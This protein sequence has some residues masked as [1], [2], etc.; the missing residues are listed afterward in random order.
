MGRREFGRYKIVEE[1]GRGAMGVVYRASDP[2]IGRT[3]AVKVVNAS[4]LEE[5][6]V[7]A[8]EYYRRFQREAE[9]AG[10][11]NHPN[12]VKIFDRGHDYLVMEFVEGQSLAA[13]IRGHV[14]LPLSRML[15][16]VGQIA[17]ALDY[18]H[19][20]G[21]VHRDVKP[22]N[23]MIQPDGVVKVMDFGLARIESS[24]LTAAGEILGSASYMA[25]E[26][27]M[28]TA[29]GAQS[30]IF[31]LGVVAYELMTGGRPFG[32]GSVSAIIQRIV[33][34]RPGSAHALN[35]SVPPDYDNI[36]LRVLAK[37]PS[38]R[39]K[40]AG[41][42]VD[43]LVL[44][45]WADRDPEA[46]GGA[47]SLPIAA[48]TAR[49]AIFPGAAEKTTTHADPADMTLLTVSA[50]EL[51]PAKEEPPGQKTT[52]ALRGEE[53]ELGGATVVTL[54]PGEGVGARGGAKTDLG[55]TLIAAAPVPPPPVLARPRATGPPPIPAPP[56]RPAPPPTGED[57][58]LAALVKD[59]PP[60]PPPTP[61]PL[62]TVTDGTP[63][64]APARPPHAPADASPGTDRVKALPVSP[65][66]DPHGHPPLVER[67]GPSL[68][69]VLGLVGL[70]FVILVAFGVG[71]VFYILRHRSAP[72]Q[73]LPPVTEAAVVPSPE[74]APPSPT[75]VAETPIPSPETQEVASS[76]EVSIPPSPAFAPALG[77]L[78]IASVPSGARVSLG[79]A[80]RGVTP[81][82]GSV[83]AGRLSV[84]VEKEGFKPWKRDVTIG[85]G[86][87]QTLRAELEPV[88]AVVPSPSVSA[89]PA[90]KTGDLVPLTPD[91]VPPRK[92]S[93]DAPAAPSAPKQKGTLS[94][95]V[96]FVVNDDGTVGGVRVVQSG[97]DALDRAALGAVSGWRYVPATL[98]GVRVKVQQRAK[99]T[100]EYR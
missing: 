69:L 52:P 71:G 5:V 2:V 95:V 31:G 64:M 14:A 47:A 51:H 22:A 48:S 74:A 36:F 96:E 23:V 3:V 63:L 58:P 24:T 54:D 40:T 21:V 93:G 75:M 78:T 29:A 13:H 35:L 57:A 15:E 9:V 43:D 6:G 87:A 30:D 1:I 61:P 38:A 32:G 50:E 83:R 11:L 84:T 25:P 66:T 7:Q 33:K 72:P 56:I 45:K 17:E 34:D 88:A 28:G 19:A 82:K 59:V 49:T 12:I 60:P 70:V 80:V 81:F 39:Y 27:I 53:P 8:E 65:L 18:A 26:V 42:F 92:I 99:F 97:G 77:S 100:F 44:K 10:R 68:G 86:G 90:L 55:A 46:R 98:Q 94:V 37:E 16:I 4:Y 76:P 20:Q 62:P 91:V 89:A 85:A 41:E 79:Q 67:K 73:E